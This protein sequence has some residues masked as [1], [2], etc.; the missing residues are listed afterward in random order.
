MTI[1]DDLANEL[2]HATRIDRGVVAVGG[3]LRVMD[4]RDAKRFAEWVVMDARGAA[5]KIISSSGTWDTAASATWSAVSGALHRLA[6]DW[7]RANSR[8]E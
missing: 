1:H 2:F 5:M 3:P 4:P 8:H 6:L 7:W